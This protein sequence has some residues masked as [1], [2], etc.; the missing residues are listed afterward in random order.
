MKKLAGALLL[1][2]AVDAAAGVSYR[3]ESST[4]TSGRVISEGTNLRLEMDNGSVLITI[5]GGKTLTILDPARKTF[6]TMGATDLVGIDVAIVNPK[7]AARDLGDGGLLQGYPTRKWSVE[8]SFDAT[9]ETFTIHVTLRSESWRTERL[10]EAAATILAGQSARTGIAA[11]DKLLESMASA[12]VKGFPLKE[13]TTIRTKGAAGDE[14]SVTSTVAVHD[15]RR[16]ATTPAQFVVPAG[17]K[18][19]H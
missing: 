16:V 18:R 4:G 9:I 15:V 6:S 1:L 14:N 19:S 7:T 12:K 17:Y 10:P 5:D 8:T 2:V 3:L 11:I 13:T